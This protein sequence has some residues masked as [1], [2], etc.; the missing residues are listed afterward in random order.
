MNHNDPLIHEVLINHIHSGMKTLYKESYNLNKNDPII[1]FQV[2]LSK[3]KDISQVSLEDEYERLLKRVEEHGNDEEFIERMIELIFRNTAKY[4]MEIQKGYFIENIQEIPYEYLNISSNKYKILHLFTL[5]SA[6]GIWPNANLYCNKYPEKEYQKN[7]EEAKKIIKNSII[8][9]INKRIKLNELYD[10]YTR[11]KINEKEEE[12]SGMDYR[13]FVSKRHIYDIEEKV[14]KSKDRAKENYQDVKSEDEEPASKYSDSESDEEHEN[15]DQT[16]RVK[17]EEKSEQ[18]EKSERDEQD[19]EDEKS[20]RDEQDEQDEKSDQDE[21]SEQSDDDE[22]DDESDQS[23]QEE[24]ESTTKNNYDDYYNVITEKLNHH[25][26]KHKEAVTAKSSNSRDYKL[27]NMKNYDNNSSDNDDNMQ[28]SDDEENVTV[29]SV[30]KHEDD[31]K[32]F[33]MQLNPSK[34]E[35]GDFQKNLDISDISNELKE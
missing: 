34:E 22:S 20:E 32:H 8:N 25:E 21:K 26:R 14:I 2:A 10:Y 18:D 27:I 30:I 1:V 17:L 4:I 16:L 19:E 29:K 15:E 12:N 28:E 7:I 3:I 6:R 23:E 9:A 33:T 31:V 5:E 24:N 13:N 35:N 11:P